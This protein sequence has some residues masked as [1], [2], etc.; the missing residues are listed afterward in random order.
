[1]GLGGNN[2]NA[3]ATSIMKPAK[4]MGFKVCVVIF[5]GAA[6]LK[7]LTPVL[8]NGNSWQDL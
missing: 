3:Y 2:N 8:Y 7:L 6:G 1:M 4:D 5:R